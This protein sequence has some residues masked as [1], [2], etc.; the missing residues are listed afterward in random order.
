M[1]LDLRNLTEA[2]SGILIENVQPLVDGGRYPL[3]REVGDRIDI[4]ADIFRE[5]HEL[6]SAVIQYRQRGD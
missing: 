4:T 5:G 2:P 6:M 1:D 3:K